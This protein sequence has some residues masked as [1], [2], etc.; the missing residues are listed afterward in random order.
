MGK[1][2]G[3]R[4]DVKGRRHFQAGFGARHPV[5]YDDKVGAFFSELNRRLSQILP[6][7]GQ[8]TCELTGL[9]ED[10]FKLYND[11][12]KIG[13]TVLERR[14]SAEHARRRRLQW[15]AND[16]GRV[17]SRIADEIARL[18][19]TED[20]L[21]LT[22]SGVVRVGDADRRSRGGKLA[23]VPE[24]AQRAAGF[25]AAEHEIVVNGLGG[26]F[27]DFRYPYNDY[28]PK[29]TV[30][31][32]YRSAEPFQVDACAEALAEMVEE[33]PLTVSLEDV[34]FFAHQEL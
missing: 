23:L 13:V 25:L 15:T 3:P 32:V 6:E 26:V 5:V 8:I 12:E 30:G 7:R 4:S 10:K 33:Q 18:D 28:T 34:V 11:P 2:L 14:L 31:R 29:L 21:R 27:K 17:R 9:P 22:L 24:G 20:E 1:V 19:M 16:I